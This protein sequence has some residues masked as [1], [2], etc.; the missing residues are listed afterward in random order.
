[1]K[2]IFALLTLLLFGCTSDVE[3]ANKLGFASV[4][5]MT[6][7]NSLGYK[8]NKDFLESHPFN[9][10]SDTPKFMGSELELNGKLLGLTKKDDMYSLGDDGY[11]LEDY[12][13]STIYQ[14]STSCGDS[15]QS[16]K[17]PTIDGI[18]CNSNEEEISKIIKSSSEYCSASNIDEVRVY[19]VNKAYFTIDPESKKIRGFG[20]VSKPEW[21]YYWETSYYQKCE[22]VKAEI[23]MSKNAG[24]ES[25]YDM[26]EASKEGVKSGKDWKIAKAVKKFK[27]KHSAA[28]NSLEKSL[29]VLVST[30][31]EFQSHKDNGGLTVNGNWR[32]YQAY[33][34]EL[35]YKADRLAFF[36]ILIN[37]DFANR[38]KP[39]TIN[40]IKRD[41]VDECGY[42]WNL[43]NSSG[44]AYI[45]ET[46]FSRCEV[47][48]SS[49][50]GFNA[51]VS[52]KTAN[53][54]K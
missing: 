30:P 8:T 54:F 31:S 24:F 40:N 3:K 21:F 13:D 23:Q 12:K 17:N 22:T 5:H 38:N 36:R 43:L 14:I 11:Y 41:L 27:E 46:E 16:K 18:G 48:T 20:F 26:R 45:S 19:F 37:T 47:S 6:Y 29:I 52:V 34:V 49:S 42:D 2:F 15:F 32:G 9:A 53:Y 10:K 4:E 51:V 50:G 35:E 7:M 33:S 25:I 1:M 44:N 28:T 39:A